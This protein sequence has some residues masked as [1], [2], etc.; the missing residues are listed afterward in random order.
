MNKAGGTCV[1][2]GA[3][4]WNCAAASPE[5]PEQM[6]AAFRAGAGGLHSSEN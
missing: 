6:A 4:R 2:C 1:H 5:N 3:C